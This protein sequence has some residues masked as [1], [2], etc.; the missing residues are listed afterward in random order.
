MD[1][2]FDLYLAGEVPKEGFGDKYRPLDERYRSLGDEAAK[3]QGEIDFLRIRLAS[4]REVLQEA[5]DLYGRWG[6]MNLEEKRKVVEEVTERITVGDKEIHLD[7]AYVPGSPP[8]MAKGSQDDR[9]RR[10]PHC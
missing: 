1:K 2:L 8:T 7:L 3:L 6:E 10:R 9:T 5:R 4:S